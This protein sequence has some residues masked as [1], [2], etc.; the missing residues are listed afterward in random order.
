MNLPLVSILIASYNH[1][2]YIGEA[3]TSILEQS[4]KNIELIVIDDGS[5]DNSYEIIQKL[6][7][8][9]GFYAGQQTNMGLS[10]TL[11]KMLVMAQGQ[12]ICQFGSDDIMM[13]DKTAKQVRFME[14]N[15][16]VAVSGGNILNIDSEGAVTNKRQRFYP[17]HE[18][19]FDGLFSGAEAGI[20][21][22]SCMIRK[23]VLDIEGGWDPAIP[24]ED[25]YLWFKLT[26]RGCRI[27][28]L[29]DVLIYYRKHET[30]TYK[31]VRYM[32]DSMCKTIAPYQEHSLYKS[33]LTKLQRS[34]FLSA[35]KQD[36]ALALAILKEIPLSAYNLKVLR[37][38]F[39]LFWPKAQ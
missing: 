21:A 34:S 15:I 36:N 39:Y 11:N 7:N 14:E 12:Y 37:G 30:N 32:Y 13:P 29:N 33:V 16:D 9:Y 25:M 1:E 4:Y 5:T 8:K 10:T 19:S 31:N 3:I 38:L 23:S 2:E 24:L 17:Q 22:S 20:A 27:I 26:S 35:A 18:I 28:G 6:A